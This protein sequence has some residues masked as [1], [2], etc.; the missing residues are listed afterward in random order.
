MQTL[1]NENRK[2]IEDKLQTHTDTHK[3]VCIHHML[4]SMHTHHRDMCINAHPLSCMH[5]PQ[6]FM[7]IHYPDP[8]L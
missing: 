7:R 8:H 6:A 3:D 1:E 4:T 2:N 5:T